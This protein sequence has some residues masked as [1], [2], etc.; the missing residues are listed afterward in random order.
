[1]RAGSSNATSRLSAAQGRTL[2]GGRKAALA[3]RHG[4]QK[5]TQTERKTRARSGREAGGGREG[6]E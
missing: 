4:R 1:M 6:S 2:V 5:Q 3:P